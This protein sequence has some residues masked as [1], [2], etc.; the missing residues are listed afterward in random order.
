MALGHCHRRA[1]CGYEAKHA[2]Y[3][4]VQAWNYMLR[5]KDNASSILAMFGQVRQNARLA[6]NAISGELWEAINENWLE[7]QE[8]LSRPV[9][10]NRVLDTV[11]TIRSIIDAARSGPQPG[12]SDA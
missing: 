12:R 7:T 1:T 11:A 4:G 9:G 2:S 8:Q 10:E 6:R 5:D 3:T